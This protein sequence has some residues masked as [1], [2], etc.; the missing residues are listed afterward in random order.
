VHDLPRMQVCTE[1]YQRR[2]R[3]LA[4][5]TDT[6]LGAPQVEAALQATLD[7]PDEDEEAVSAAAILLVTASPL[8]A[9][10]APLRSLRAT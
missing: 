6:D 7:I 8:W 5:H 9:I 1:A 4:R 2:V 3:A 10:D